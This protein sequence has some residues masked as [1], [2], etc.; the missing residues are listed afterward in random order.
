MF[1]EDAGQRVMNKLDELEIALD[2][3]YDNALKKNA[4]LYVLIET[5]VLEKMKND[6]KKKGVSLSEW[7]RQKLRDDS[8]LDRIERKIKELSG[9][10]DN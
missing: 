9:K 2:K 1:E 7:C 8:Q 5:D 10:I 3:T 6:A 4:H